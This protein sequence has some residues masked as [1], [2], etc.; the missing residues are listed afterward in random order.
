MSALGEEIQG[1]A[2]SR[3]GISFRQLRKY[4]ECPAS[5]SDVPCKKEEIE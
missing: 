4:T 3:E 1:Q 2:Q 5:H